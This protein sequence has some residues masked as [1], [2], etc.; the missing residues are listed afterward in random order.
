MQAANAKKVECEVNG[1]DLELIST[2]VDIL[3][4]ITDKLNQ[5]GGQI[6][7]LQISDQNLNGDF[8]INLNS[9]S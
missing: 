5:I 7:I 2:E 3:S 8:R 4:A 6:K 1:E 9:E